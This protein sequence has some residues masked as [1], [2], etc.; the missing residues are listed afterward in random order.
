MTSIRSDGCHMGC[1]IIPSALI[2]PG[3]YPTSEN[4][5]H[6]F[7]KIGFCPLWKLYIFTTISV[8]RFGD[9]VM[10]ICGIIIKE[11]YIV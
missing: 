11:L 5:L 4:E 10:I 1:S 8:G 3:M 7:L 9:S 6:Y 2:M